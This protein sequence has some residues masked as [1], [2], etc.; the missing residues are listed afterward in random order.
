MFSK[1]FKVVQPKV[2]EQFYDIVDKKDNYILIKIDSAMICKADIRYYNGERDK[3]ILGMKYPMSLIHEAIG[4][5]VKGDEE[6]YKVGDRVV[7]IPNFVSEKHDKNKCK[8][9]SDK[10]L[11]EN[12]CEEAKFSSSN[13]D[14]F[15]R[16]YIAYP[17]EYV[18]KLP[19]REL[20]D[21]YVF[22]ELISVCVA[23]I[24]RYGDI[25]K[26]NV[27][28][29]GDGILGYI[30]ASLL[31]F[32]FKC[33][34]TVIGKH[35]EKLD[36]VT[37]AK[38]LFYGEKISR[39]NIVFECV[40]GKGSESAINSAI[41]NI[42]V[43]GS[44]VLMGV[45]EEYISINTRKVLEKGIMILGSSRSSKDDF[46]FAIECLDNIE[47]RKSIKMLIIDEVEINDIKDF[48]DAFERE[49]NNKN[50]GREILKFNF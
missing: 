42:E 25:Y 47:F 29:Y 39:F 49:A 31:T 23:A 3:R 13:V 37:F 19:Q 38:T 41:D 28:V 30:M 35:K 12:Y 10:K 46:A 48:Y 36:K 17:S 34:V 18:L 6:K 16:E 26:E 11:G 9:C 1:N 15:S 50:I 33:N 14:G 32:V 40:G 21:E 45:S 22:L 20:I 43:G 44:V 27:A 5:I 4:T 8:I 2:F 24:R 7:L